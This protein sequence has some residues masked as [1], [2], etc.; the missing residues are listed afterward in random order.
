M[1][2]KKKE[3]KKQKGILVG[4][5]FFLRGSSSRNNIQPLIP[6]ISYEIAAKRKRIQRAT[7]YP[8][9]LDKSLE[10]QL[11]KLIIEPYRPTS[12]QW[13]FSF[14]RTMHV[15]IIDGL[16]E[17]NGDDSQVQILSHLDRLV[18]DTHRSIRCLIASRPEP[19]IISAVSTLKAEVARIT[20][21][22]ISWDANGDIRTYLRAG[23]DNISTRVSPDILRPWPSDSVVDTLVREVGG[24]F[25]Y[26]ATVLKYIDKC[27]SLTT[28]QLE[29]V[30]KLV[31]GT[32]PFAE[33]DQLYRHI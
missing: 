8:S 13:V 9:I 17:C 11:D 23:F 20:L 32:T 28:T 33:L 27:D 6:T 18:R 22:D 5:Y 24:I 29:H 14:R 21:N 19:H 1:E 26:A 31:P 16:D 4:S 12:F 7:T 25:I 10:V 15:F 2:S 3:R 30:L